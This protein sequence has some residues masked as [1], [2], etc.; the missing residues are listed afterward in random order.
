MQIGLYVGKHDKCLFDTVNSSNPKT[1]H[2]QDDSMSHGNQQG[3]SLS[4][5]MMT[6]TS[7]MDTKLSLTSRRLLVTSSESHSQHQQM[8]SV[9]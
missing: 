1:Q 7:T 8:N 9:R 5:L 2:I 6:H 4:Q 3:S